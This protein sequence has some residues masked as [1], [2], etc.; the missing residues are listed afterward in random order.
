ML[1]VFL[2]PSLLLLRL[3]ND[4]F[5][6][7][8]LDLISEAVLQF[9]RIQ[10]LLVAKLLFENLALRSPKRK[11]NPLALF[12]VIAYSFTNSIQNKLVLAAERGL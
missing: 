10:F 2:H 3:N 4:N 7:G 6:H 8:L 1:R 5:G 12:S 9:S 11:E